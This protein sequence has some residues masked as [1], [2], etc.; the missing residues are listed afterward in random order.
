M[1]AQTDD[2]ARVA[3]AVHSFLPRLGRSERTDV[4]PPANGWIAVDDE[5]CSGHPTLLRRLA[6]ELSYRT[7]G[8]VLTLGVEEG[9]V[10]RYVLFD[11]GSI[12][13]EYCSLPEYHGLL[14]P[15]DVVALS[16]NP[17]VAQRLTGRRS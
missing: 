2:E 5:L 4:Y 12:A 6:Q 11:K 15:G 10:V 9:A 7:G 3:K 1:F 17:T 14:P 16:A 13:D 8:V